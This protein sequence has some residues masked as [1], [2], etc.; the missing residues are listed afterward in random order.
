MFC[1]R[2]GVGG[3]GFGGSYGYGGFNFFMMI[4]MIIILFLVAYFIYKVINS[5]NLNFT[6]GTSS[7]KAMAILN[8]RFAKGEIS[9]EEYETKKN[10]ILK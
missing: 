6:V 1:N 8:E 9:E 5:R 10:Q 7:S 3:Y 4:P 2:F